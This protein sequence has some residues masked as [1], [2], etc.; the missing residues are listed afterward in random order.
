M[1]R[2]RSV[3]ASTSG[4]SAR[5]GRCS[6]AKIGGRSSSGNFTNP[7]EMNDENP[8]Y[9]RP[10]DGPDRR[11]PDFAGAEASELHRRDLSHRHRTDRYLR[12]RRH[13]PAHLTTR[14]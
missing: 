14:P 2:L 10:P 3:E 9:T 6:T 13:A 7:G 1:D 12:L 5:A 11:N 8:F 4:R